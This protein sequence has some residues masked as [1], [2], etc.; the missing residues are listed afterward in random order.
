M[1]N[2]KVLY[3]EDDLILQ[4]VT[5]SYMEMES[6]ELHI[7]GNGNDGVDLFKQVAPDVVVTDL[8]MPGM[9]GLEVVA[10]INKLSPMTPVIVMSGMGKM[11]DSI[12]ALRL[13]AW[14][15]LSKPC[16]PSDL[17]HTVKKA[18]EHFDLLK[19]NSRYQESLEDEVKAR[20]SELEEE[21]NRRRVAEHALFESEQKFRA[22]FDQAFHFI[23]L[24]DASGVLIE[25][26]NTAR[27]FMDSIGEGVLEKPIWESAWWDA[28]P[29]I[30]L[31]IKNAVN[32]ASEGVF[33]NFE[34]KVYAPDGTYIYIDFSLKP[35]INKVGQVTVLIAEGHDVTAHKLVQSELIEAKE[36]AEAANE[37][38]SEFLSNMSHEIRTPMHWILSYARFGLDKTDSAPR[39]KL[40]SFFEEINTGGEQLMVLIEN[41]FDLSKMAMGEMEYSMENND[42]SV[43]VD[44]VLLDCSTTL[45]KKGISAQ[46]CLNTSD[47]AVRCDQKR[48]RQVLTNLID[49]AVKFTTDSSDIK[50]EISR[51]QSVRPPSYVLDA[52]AG[53]DLT[54]NVL[55]VRVVNHGFGIPENE[56][57]SVFDSFSQSSK[58]K[59]GAGGT[60]LGLAIC[61][62]III[63]HD[64]LIWVENNSATQETIFSFTLPC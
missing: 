33:V 62:D 17:V 56:L 27:E 59:D 25:L 42:F 24:T 3:I 9:D 64:G 52:S 61:R 41:L 46:V 60:G 55:L 31:K 5:Q 38:K 34:T 13:G 48:I 14:D 6:I 47:T 26:N 57:N 49:N 53:G 4:Q 51:E 7:A 18:F 19:E 54:E 11:D 1:S 23:A 8:R 15:Y 43:L 29:Q 10:A 40:L 36:R 2:R 16:K 45:D 63:A 12:E 30:Q 28:D 50:L 35:I 37:A 39:E 58:T 44:S 22:I 21:L 20:T 32:T